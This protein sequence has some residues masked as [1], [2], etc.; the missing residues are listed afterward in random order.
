MFAKLDVLRFWFNESDSTTAQLSVH[1][2]R[3]AGHIPTTNTTRGRDRT[4]YSED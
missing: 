2:S 3:R 4:N 1:L